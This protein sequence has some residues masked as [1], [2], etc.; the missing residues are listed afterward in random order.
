MS[1]TSRNS[2]ATTNP[3]LVFESQN[4]SGD[5]AITDCDIVYDDTSSSSVPDSIAFR[6]FSVAGVLQATDPNTKG[7]I[8]VR[9]HARGT[10]T[11]NSVPTAFQDQNLDECMGL[12]PSFSAYKSASTTDVTGDG[13]VVDVIFDTELHD[14]AGS[15]D[16]A[17]GIFTADRDGL[18]EFKASALLYGRTAAETRVVLQLVTSVKSF[19]DDATESNVVIPEVVRRVSVDVYLKKGQTAKAQVVAY[20]GTKVVDLLGDSTQ[21]VTFFSGKLVRG[22][23]KSL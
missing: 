19:S 4:D 7:R 13:T 21:I 18:Y 5:A 6:H 10:I 23:P 16:N 12:M 1:F 8:R 14:H 3:Q 9:G 15:Y 11:Y 17:T 22:G 20:N 2:L